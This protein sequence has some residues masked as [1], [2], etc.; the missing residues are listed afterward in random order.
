MVGALI[1]YW[2]GWPYNLYIGLGMLVGF[3]VYLYYHVRERYPVEDLRAG[4]WLAVMIL[5]EI[6]VSYA[7]SFGGRGL[8]P[9]PW[10]IVVVVLASVVF[11]YW[12]IASG[13]ETEAVRRYRQETL[14]LEATPAD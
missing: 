10:D 5:F 14:S 9:Y 13:Y 2:T 1:I 4:L 7:G 8:L 3:A 12:A 6:A 11:Y